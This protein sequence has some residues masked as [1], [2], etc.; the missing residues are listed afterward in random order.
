MEQTLLIRK[1]DGKSLA[2]KIDNF[3]KG[4]SNNFIQLT[5][6]IFDKKLR[7]NSINSTSGKLDIGATWQQE[8]KNSGIVLNARRVHSSKRCLYEHSRC[9]I[10]V[11]WSGWGIY[12]HWLP[13]TGLELV[14]IR[15]RGCVKCRNPEWTSTFTI[16]QS[17][18]VWFYYRKQANENQWYLKKS[19]HVIE[20]IKYT[21][22]I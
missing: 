11:L 9:K 10:R 13:V 15:N 20:L 21:H 6:G 3:S 4:D 16:S 12:S 22:K 5:K 19:N 7:W 2:C 1:Y 8:S 18:F 14:N 17:K